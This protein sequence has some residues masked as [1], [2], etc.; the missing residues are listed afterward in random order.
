MSSVPTVTAPL[1]GRREPALYAIDDWRGSKGMLLF[2]ATEAALFIML[3]FAYFY[4]GSFNSR[5]PLDEP[6]KLMLALIMLGVLIASS[7][8][9]HAGERQVKQ[10]NYRA[11]RGLLLLTIGIGIAFMV[12]Q[13]FEYREHLKTLQPQSD[14]YGSIFYTITSFHG[15]HLIVGLLM[16]AYVLI[17]P[18]GEPVDRPPHQPYHNAAMYWHFVDAVWILIVAIL[19]VAPNLPR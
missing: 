19:Y 5:W 16:L 1:S 12:L 6:P 18:R 15:A 14:S 10:R 2:I 9:L 8:V 3:F 4:L 17:L 7:I 11:A 13:V